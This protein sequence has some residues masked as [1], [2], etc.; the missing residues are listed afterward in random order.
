[1]KLKKLL[2]GIKK[3][4]FININFIINNKFSTIFIS[5]FCINSIYNVHGISFFNFFIFLIKNI[6]Y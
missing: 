6:F 1:M 3:I 2:T 4:K 5:N